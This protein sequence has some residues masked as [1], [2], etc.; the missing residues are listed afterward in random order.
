GA[1]RD[2]VG[3]AR[4][5]RAIAEVDGAALEGAAELAHAPADRAAVG[6]L[7]RRCGDDVG[8]RRRERLGHGESDA[9]ARARDDREAARKVEEVVGHGGS[10]GQ[11]CTSMS[12]LRASPDSSEANAARVSES[13][14]VVV[15]SSSA[16]TAPSATSAI[17]RSKSSRS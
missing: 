15:T 3:E 2:I 9:A 11:F 13:G 14:T 7:A 8:P 5:G 16:G 17:A 10:P 6:L 12:T 4:H 1:I